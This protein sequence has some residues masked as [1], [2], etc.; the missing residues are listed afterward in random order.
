MTNIDLALVISKPNI[1]RNKIEAALLRCGVHSICCENFREARTLLPQDEYRVVLCTDNLA[2]G[3]IQAVLSAMQKSG[4]AA[5][6]IVLSHTTNWNSNLEALGDGAF[7]FIDCPLQFADAEKILRAALAV[8]P[9]ARGN[10]S[11]AA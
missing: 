1:D 8:K 4:V 5:P 2:D 6:L 10:A 7:S 9:S 11:Q 3:D